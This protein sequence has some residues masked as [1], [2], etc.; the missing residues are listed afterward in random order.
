M[1]YARGFCAAVIVAVLVGGCGGTNQLTGGIVLDHTRA[2]V[3]ENVSGKLV[4]HNRTSSRV[5]LLRANSCG[6]L[7]DVTLRSA[8]WMQPA[9]FTWD[10]G[11]EEALIAKPGVTVY[12][13]TIHA[14]SQSCSATGP[15]G[16]GLCAKD[17]HGNRDIM[18]V[19]PAG[20]YTTVFTPG[21]RWHGPRIREATLVVTR[22]R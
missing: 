2:A 8:K 21:T 11:D 15:R 7:Y 6:K 4:I 13:F 12:R 1:T 3:G 5:V 19:A 9:D 14:R 16:P 17:A 10:C 20:R 22:A 18:P